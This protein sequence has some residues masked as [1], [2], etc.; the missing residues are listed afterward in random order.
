MPDTTT[1][2]TRRKSAPKNV[3]RGRPISRDLRSRIE[4]ALEIITQD[5]LAALGSC[6]GATVS[7]A[8]DHYDIMQ[9]SID[10]LHAC[11]EAHEARQAEPEPTEAI[12][13]YDETDDD[14]DISCFAALMAPDDPPET[15][16]LETLLDLVETWVRRPR[17]DETEIRMI[18]RALMS[19]P[20]PEG[21]Q[22][23]LRCLI[24]T[25]LA[26]AN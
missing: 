15:H 23:R 16:R 10:A 3:S 8:L 6:S 24:Q 20:I 4:G 1:T 9:A 21:I 22:H 11:C 12:P 14:D 25:S 26:N 19:M 2:P 17:N 13:A 18:L 7:R 5:Q